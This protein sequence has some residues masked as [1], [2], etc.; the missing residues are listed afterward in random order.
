M[1]SRV[2]RFWRRLPGD[3]KE[4]LA[5]L[6]VPAAIESFEAFGRSW[7]A[8]VECAGRR[9]ELVSHLGYVDVSKIVGSAYRTV[10]PPEDQRM[11]I[12][13][14]QV[15]EL[16]QRELTEPRATAEGET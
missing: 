14:E 8:R 6:P 4:I 2:R 1:N 10:M 15:C 9:F 7:R 16:M 13:L 3:L 11:Q 12:S 5:G